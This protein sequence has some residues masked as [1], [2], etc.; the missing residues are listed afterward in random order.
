MQIPY[1]LIFAVLFS[2]PTFASPLP[3][4]LANEV[5]L[6]ARKSKAVKKPAARPIVKVKPKAKAVKKPTVPKAKTA[7]K[8]K[9]VAGTKKKVVPGAA[10]TGVKTTPKKVVPSKKV[11]G[12]GASKAG[13]KTPIKKPVTASKAKSAS[14]V[15][16]KS[17]AKAKSSASKKPVA[18]SCPIKPAGKA[19]KAGKATTKT[20]KSKRMMTQLNAFARKV[21]IARR[22]LFGLIRP[23]LTEGG[24]FIGWH[25]T[26]ENTAELWESSGEIVRPT[27]KEGQTIGKS[28]LDAEL[29]A[30]LYISDTLGVAESAAAINA[31]NNNLAGK[32]CAIFAKS[33]ANWREARDKVQIPEI[34]RGNPALKEKERQS[35]IE[36]L[37]GKSTT[38]RSPAVLFGPLS[39]T[40]NQIMIVESLNPKFEAQCFDIVGLDSADAQAF[41]DEGNKVSYT[42][43]SLIRDWEIR[44]E[45]LEFAKATIAAFEKC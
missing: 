14:K 41:E 15:P 26:N 9:P 3:T 35:Y 1:A 11:P 2:I 36:N 16:T 20:K 6:E 12:E 24:E 34:L 37:P 42:S 40:K 28:G 5:A 45:D 8:A 30:G 18:S 43:A 31:K 27:S 29:G 33:S 32:V 25:G 17:A 39:S 44:T 19:G 23:R 13:A 21:V 10:K 4:T 7:A 38:S 22:S